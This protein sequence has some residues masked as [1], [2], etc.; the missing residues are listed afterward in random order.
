MRA[1]SNLTLLFALAWNAF[2]QPSLPAFEVASVKAAK[3]SDTHKWKGGPGTNDPS[4]FEAMMDLQS[5]ARIAWD[6]RRYQAVAPKNMEDLYVS[7]TA[8]VPPGTDEP[9]FHRMLQQLLITRMKLEVQYGVREVPAYDLVVAKG[10]AKLQPAELAPSASTGQ[11]TPAGQIP[12][13]KTVRDK[14]GRQQLPPGVPR[15]F[16][17]YTAGTMRYMV[18][19]LPMEKIL[20]G[21]A[22]ALGRPVVDKTGLTGNYDF[23]L[24]FSYSLSADSAVAD[25]ASSAT[26]EARLAAPLLKD[27]IEQQLGLKL[28]S[29]KTVDRVLTVISFSKTPVEN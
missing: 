22:D 8:K 2:A 27:A 21:I 14:E 15:F 25:P 11:P 28:Q 24:E 23:V 26:P 16:S 3:E 18:R 20:P 4:R 29:S 6:V 5:L 10:G 17:Q 9:T 7:I 13:V 1:L 19:M 12:V